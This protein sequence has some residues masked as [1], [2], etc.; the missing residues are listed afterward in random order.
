MSKVHHDPNSEVGNNKTQ[1]DKPSSVS[2]RRILTGVTSAAVVGLVGA[3][4]ART[5]QRD[6]RCMPMLT[7]S[8]STYAKPIPVSD[9]TSTRVLVRR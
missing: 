4:R 6:R 8:W 1:E 2:R 9:C 3:M 5:V 7:L